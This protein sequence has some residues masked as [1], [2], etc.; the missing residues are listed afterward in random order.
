[1]ERH[2]QGSDHIWRATE[3]NASHSSIFL[4]FSLNVVAGSQ[5]QPPSGP[6]GTDTTP[7][8]PT[9]SQSHLSPASSH[10]LTSL[11]EAGAG[12]ARGQW[13]Q[14]QPITPWSF[15]GF[16]FSNVHPFVCLSAIYSQTQMKQ[17][18]VSAWHRLWWH[19]HVQLHGWWG[20]CLHVLVCARFLVPA[21][22]SSFQSGEVEKSVPAN[23]TTS[24]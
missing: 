16:L 15:Q 24:F 23:I 2:L 21:S 19:V 12:Q 9:R 7:I 22:G 20:L 10:R 5:S 8:N 13:D 14:R 1:M 4:R 11:G 18:A 17:S 6:A 3:G